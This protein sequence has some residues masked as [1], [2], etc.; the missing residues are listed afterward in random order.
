MTRQWTGELSAD[1]DEVVEAGF[2]D[3]PPGE[4]H[5]PTR[6]VLGLYAAYRATGLFQAR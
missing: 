5:P 4:L 6:V 2:F 1:A 3:G